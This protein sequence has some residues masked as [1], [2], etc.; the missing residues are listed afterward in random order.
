MLKFN[1]GTNW[2]GNNITTL[3]NWISISSYNI[4][5]L[6]MAIDESRKVLRWNTIIA[7]IVSTFAGTLNITQF[8]LIDNEYVNLSIK[9]LLTLLTFTV[10]INAGRI[11]IYQYQESLEDYIKVKQEWIS[12][13]VQ[14]STELQLPIR[15]R[16]DALYLIETYKDKYLDLLKFEC[17]ISN[18]IKEKIKGKMEEDVKRGLNKKPTGSNLHPALV[19]KTGIKI[20]EIVF[21]IA[22]AEGLNL[23]IAETDKNYN[24]NK[25][26]NE[27][28]DKITT[29]LF[30]HKKK[31]DAST[32]IEEEYFQTVDFQPPPSPTRNFRKFTQKGT[33]VEFA[34]NG[35]FHTVSDDSTLQISSDSPPVDTKPDPKIEIVIHGGLT[36]TSNIIG[37]SATGSEISFTGTVSSLRPKC[38]IE[39]A[40]KEENYEPI[41]TKQERNVKRSLSLKKKKDIVLDDDLG[42]RMKTLE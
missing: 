40:P 29:K 13:V 30:F 28:Y 4:E 38:K 32:Y 15:L 35:H 23:L 41:D 34:P 16:R 42:S 22:Y 3:L 21:D 5:C 36:G 10:A 14:I 7:L 9:I 20:S 12:F 26:V 25:D 39:Y 19:S 37:S 2:T 17:E 6:E 31:L 27:I 8:N 11:K 1:V 18:K 24:P 33:S